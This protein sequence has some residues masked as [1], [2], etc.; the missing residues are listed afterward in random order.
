[1]RLL[2]LDIGAGTTD[3]LLYDSAAAIENCT[4]VVVPSASGVLAGRVREITEKGADLLITGSTVGGGA[5]SQAVKRHVAAGYRV[6]MTEAA[7]YTIRNDLADVTAAGIRLVPEAPAG[8]AG[9]TLTADELDLAPLAGLLRSTGQELTTLDG[10]AVAVQD[11]GSYASGESNRKTRIAHM[12]ESLQSNPSP[13]S[14]AYSLEEVPERFPRFRSAAARLAEQL[15]GPVLVM[16]TA[17][18]AIVGCM[19]DPAVARAARGEVLL[20]NAGNGHTMAAILR[21]ESVIALLEH[22]TRCLEPHAFADYLRAFCDGEAADDDAFME[23]GHGLFYLEEPGGLDALEMI[24]VTGP[25]RSLLDRSG[26][27][28]FFPAPGGDMMMTGPMGLV[29]A[30]FSREPSSQRRP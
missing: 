1:M 16:D 27:P 2:A 28:V 18:A 25:N 13:A 15:P 10:A 23:A 30:W 17:P 3:I 21:G 24:A 12:K 20:I 7:A 19:A 9:E 8:F 5:F 26:L 6:L 4:K 29:R 22:H 14:M 11:H